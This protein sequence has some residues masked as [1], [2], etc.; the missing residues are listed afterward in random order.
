M[1]TSSQINNR[2]EQERKKLARLNNEL[3]A[4]TAN[5]KKLKS[6]FKKARMILI[7]K[8]V[9]KRKAEKKLAIKKAGRKSVA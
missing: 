8:A 6:E 3:T 7:A 9:E 4:T 2:L 5:V 1:P